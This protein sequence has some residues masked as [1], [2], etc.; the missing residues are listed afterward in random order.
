MNKPIIPV[1]E[2]YL[3]QREKAL[4]DYNEAI[5]L[6]PGDADVYINRGN[7]LFEGSRFELAIRDYSEAIR[8]S[9]NYVEAYHN[10]G[11]VYRRIG[12]YVESDKDFSRGAGL[13]A[14]T[15]TGEGAAAK[16]P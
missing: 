8:I 12:R 1:N 2:P 11:L 10:R 13:K 5:R 4:E 3:G 6:D 14:S 7:V 15:N 16:S 9:P